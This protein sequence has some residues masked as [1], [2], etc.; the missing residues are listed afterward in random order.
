MLCYFQIYSKVIQL[1]MYLFLFFL[2]LKKLFIYLAASGLGCSTWDLLL[3]H[4]DSLVLAFQ[5]SSCSTWA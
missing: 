4:M 1:Y 5:L 3:Q 2:F